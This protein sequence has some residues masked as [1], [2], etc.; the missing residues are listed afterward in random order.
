M[1]FS[2]FP[3]RNGITVSGTYFPLCNCSSSAGD[4]ILIA[5][6]TRD[7]FSWLFTTQG[8]FVACST[9][10]SSTEFAISSVAG[11]LSKRSKLGVS[12]NLNI[13]SNGLHFHLLKDGV[14]GINQTFSENRLIH[15]I[16]VWL[17]CCRDVSDIGFSCS[18]EKQPPHI[19]GAL[20]FI[21][22]LF[23]LCSFCVNSVHWL[24]LFGYTT[25]FAL[26][27]LGYQKRVHWTFPASY[28]T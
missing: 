28:W 27:L 26:F 12:D 23:Y 21:L 8:F 4:L 14:I 11:F 10:S 6:L 9:N 19:R 22:G 13:W 18:E 1:S 20:V 7:C 3:F 24:L 15:Q 2:K 5:F 25:F 17:F 16:F